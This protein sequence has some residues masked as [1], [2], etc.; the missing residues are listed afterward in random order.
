MR[1]KVRAAEK[2]DRTAFPSQWK[3]YLDF[4]RIVGFLVPDVLNLIFLKIYSEIKRPN[5]TE[6]S[7]QLQR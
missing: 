5:F 2:T 6:A 3:T 1:Q 4:E 7:F